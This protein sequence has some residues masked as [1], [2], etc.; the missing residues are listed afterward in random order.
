MR[1][2]NHPILGSLKRGKVVT[3]LVDGKDIKAFE[4]VPCRNPLKS[5]ILER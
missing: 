5:D 3:I 4:G 2:Y 1:I